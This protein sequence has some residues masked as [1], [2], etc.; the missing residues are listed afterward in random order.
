[1]IEKI[2]ENA[3]IIPENTATDPEKEPSG[4]SSTREKLLEAE[5]ACEKVFGTEW[6]ELPRAVQRDLK[7]VTVGLISYNLKEHQIA[8][9]LQLHKDALMS[10]GYL[11]PRFE[12]AN[13]KFVI[14]KIQELVKDLVGQENFESKKLDHAAR[15]V[16]DINGLK[17]TNDLAGHQAGD[18][19]LRRTVETFK[20]GKTASWVKNELGM[21]LLLSAEGGDELTLLLT[22]KESLKRK[23]TDPVTGEEGELLEIILAGYWRDIRETKV[24]DLLDFSKPEI[25]EKWT[26]ENPPE[27]FKFMATICGGYG[28]LRDAAEKLK[29]ASQENMDNDIFTKKLVHEFFDLAD[30]KMLDNKSVFKDSLSTGN[31]RERFLAQLYQRDWAL[32]E[33]NKRLTLENIRQKIEIDQLKQEIED[34]RK[35]LAATGQ[36]PSNT[37][38]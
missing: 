17:N 4:D 12:I 10:S 18:E 38:I 15:F 34:L 31:P 2:S 36:N 16:F 1:M 5:E 14:S 35:K 6:K 25:R 29:A 19:F 28:T 33:E 24:D 27:D 13:K 37:A 22:D 9:S 23:A 20:T 8:E 7:K 26:G 32:A 3:D 30:Q 21:D 11:D